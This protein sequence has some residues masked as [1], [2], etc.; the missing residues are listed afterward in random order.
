[1]KPTIETLAAIPMAVIHTET[2]CV[3][4]LIDNPRRLPRIGDSGTRL[5]CFVAHDVEVPWVEWKKGKPRLPG[6]PRTPRTFD[7]QTVRESF[8]AIK[9]EEDA[10]RFLNECGSFTS[11][12][13]AESRHGWEL[14]EL[15]ACQSLFGQLTT[16]PPSTWGHYAQ[17]LIS[18][19]SYLHPGMLNDIQRSASH[20]VEF[21]W[22]D[23][24]P[25][26]W[27]GATHLAVIKTTNVVAT[28]LATIEIDHLRGAT[29]RL[30][31]RPDCPRS[32]EIT[33][34][35]N[36]IYCSQECGHLV[37]VR[38]TRERRGQHAQRQV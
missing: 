21:H 3:W 37:S 29:F 2:P 9:G 34:K 36:R 19:G 33:S 11:L 14:R 4:K 18:P 31:A 1:M 20:T 13:D 7:G 8:M 32:F 22:K 26:H 25:V 15:L 38:N 17:T 23:L 30:C 5:R 6:P 16:R 24:R 10:L 35:H 27:H 12:A 28:I